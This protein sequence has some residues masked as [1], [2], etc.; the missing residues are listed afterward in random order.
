MIN[1]RDFVI[2]DDVKILAVD[3]L[4]HR[5]MLK[6]E[7]ILEGMSPESVIRA[8]LNGVEVPKNYTRGI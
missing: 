4:S 6:M 7:C 8:V 1:G 2:P 3:A 5:I